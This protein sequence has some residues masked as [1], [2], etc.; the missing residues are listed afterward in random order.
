MHP[1]IGAFLEQWTLA[2]GRHRMPAQ[3]DIPLSGLAPL[4]PSTLLFEAQGGS[5]I[6]RMAGTAVCAQFGRE[7]ANLPFESLWSSRDSEDA[8]RLM[9]GL[10]RDASPT[11]VGVTVTKRGHG[12]HAAELLLAPLRNGHGEPQRVLGCYTSADDFMIEGDQVDTLSIA[13]VRVIDPARVTP[14]LAGAG[15]PANDI[16]LR[17][18]H[19]VL[20]KN[21]NERFAS[22][23]GSRVIRR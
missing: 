21:G 16:A 9:V 18:G 3:N 15:L 5:F 13:S 8:V 23:S 6:I 17:R 11:L 10:A 12:R 20:L 19:L 1:R 7:L 4:L 2:K 22:N 14:G